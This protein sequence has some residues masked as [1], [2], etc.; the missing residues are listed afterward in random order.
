MI[1][2]VLGG[3]FLLL[4]VLI[5]WLSGK[6]GPKCPSPIKGPSARVQVR[7]FLI[8]DA[9]FEEAGGK[10]NKPLTLEKLTKYLTKRGDIP[11]AEVQAIMSALDTNGSECHK[12][13]FE[14]DLTCAVLSSLTLTPI[15]RLWLCLSAWGSPYFDPLHGATLMDGATKARRVLGRL[16]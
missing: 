10:K 2:G 12:G 7:A 4:L 5:L 13:G 14:R 1:G 16:P 11:L 15:L 6:L 9:V 3:L 8:A